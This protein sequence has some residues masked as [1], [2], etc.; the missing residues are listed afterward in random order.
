MIVDAV[1]HLNIFREFY[2]IRFDEQI[3]KASAIY[4]YWLLFYASF[5]RC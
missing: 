2:Y 1:P 3:K 5:G 4:L